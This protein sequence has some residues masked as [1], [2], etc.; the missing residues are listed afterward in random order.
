LNLHEAEERISTAQLIVRQA[1]ENLELASGR[2]AAGLGN[3]LEVTDAQITYSNAKTSHIQAL[4][5]YN[6]AVAGL[7]KAVGVR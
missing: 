7:E 6:V 2:Y 3:P 4:S 1:Q 5:D